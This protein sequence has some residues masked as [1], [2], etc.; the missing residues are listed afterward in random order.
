MMCYRVLAAHPNDATDT[1]LLIVHSGDRLV[2]VDTLRLRPSAGGVAASGSVP[3]DGCRDGI[4]HIVLATT[5]GVGISRRLVFRLRS[6]RLAR[7]EIRRASPA[8]GARALQTCEVCLRDGDGKPLQGDYAV[9]VVDEAFVGGSRLHDTDNIV[10]DL[11]L[12]GDLRGYVHNPAWNFGGDGG[13]GDEVR[14]QAVD[15]LML[16]NGWC[17]FSTDSMGVVHDVEFRHPLEEREWLSGSIVNLTAKDRECAS[18]P[19]TVMDTAGRSIGMS[20]LDEAGRFFVGDLNYPNESRLQIR[21]L[22]KSRRPHYVFDRP[23]FPAFRHKEPFARDGGAFVVDT[24]SDDLLFRDRNNTRTRILDNVEVSASR[25]FKKS[26]TKIYSDTKDYHYIQDNYDVYLYDRGF[27]VVN[28]LIRSE[29]GKYMDEMD[30]FDGYGE[31]F[32][33]HTDAMPGEEPKKWEKDLAPRIRIVDGEGRR[34]SGVRM[35]Q[36][37]HAEDIDRIDCDVQL[38]MK[39]R[40]EMQERIVTVYLKPGVTISEKIPDRRRTSYYTFG[41]TPPVEFYNPVYETPEQRMSPMP[42]R[43]KTLRWIPSVQSDGHGRLA[44]RYY[45]SDHIAPRRVV[46]EGVTFDGRP[47]RVEGILHP[48]NRQ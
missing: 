15:L 47:V 27:D 29:W 46:V 3:L 14:R 43:R 23:T 17:R 9:S 30:A 16:T 44:F 25:F 37:V 19:I 6:G 33:V 5:D 31:E 35:L 45:E 1:L 42:D 41:Y 11:L 12:T 8:A 13:D 38:V 24:T 32:V 22:T 28:A 21:A 39:L 2:A 20:R 18:I 34:K 4:S 36:L 7:G 40:G 26:G 10:S 48:E